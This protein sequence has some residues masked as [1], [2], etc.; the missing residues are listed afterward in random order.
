MGCVGT[1][2]LSAMRWVIQRD[3]EPINSVDW[4]LAVV[5]VLVK[6]MTCIPTETV[7]RWIPS[8]SASRGVPVYQQLL[9]YSLTDPGET[10]HSAVVVVAAGNNRT[11]DLA[12]R[13]PVL[14]HMST[15]ILVTEM[16][17]MKCR[18]L[19]VETRWCITKRMVCDSQWWWWWRVW[20]FL[21][22]ILF[23]VHMPQVKLP[24]HHRRQGR[25]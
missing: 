24:V 2:W 7:R 11:C 13:S 14:H 19:I 3:C 9:W 18:K 17:P 1:C 22:F 16:R 4:T 15:S 5:T 20:T 6:V 8:N 10:A 25:F 21:P 12:I 23:S